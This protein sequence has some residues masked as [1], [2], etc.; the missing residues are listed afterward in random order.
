MPTMARG[1]GVLPQGQKD[2]RLDLNAGCHWRYRGEGMDGNCSQIR[3][4]DR[5]GIWPGCGPWAAEYRGAT[6]HQSMLTTSGPQRP[7]EQA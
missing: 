5:P 7:L 3:R 4:L 1:S 2:D 6:A